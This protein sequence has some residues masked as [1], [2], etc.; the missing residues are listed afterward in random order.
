MNEYLIARADD[1][2]VLALARTTGRTPAGIAAW[3]N[4][5]DRGELDREAETGRG[6]PLM[7][8]LHRAPEAVAAA[9]LA[10]CE[11]GRRDGDGAP[12]F[13]GARFAALRSAVLAAGAEVEDDDGHEYLL[14][15]WGDGDDLSLGLMEPA[16]VVRTTAA[17]PDDCFFERYWMGADA[18]AAVPA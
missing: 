9:I 13:S 14:L 15:R 1:A 11:D 5:L 12:E 4:D 18:P 2:D 8:A 3:A 6:V 7:R 10:A 17:H 16:L